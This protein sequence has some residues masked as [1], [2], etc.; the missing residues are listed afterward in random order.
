MTSFANV[1]PGT[2]VK[3]DVRALNDFV[4]QTDQP[5]IFRAVIRVLAGGC[6]ALDQRDVLILVPPTP[7]VIQ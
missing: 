5:Q 1:T 6:S 2:R 4:P 3:F 7:I